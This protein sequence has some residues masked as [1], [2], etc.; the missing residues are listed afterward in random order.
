MGAEAICHFQFQRVDAGN[1]EIDVVGSTC[2][3]TI[4]VPTIY[5]NDLEVGI[6]SI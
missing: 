6:Q 3:I 4:C 5:K 2:Q 1:R